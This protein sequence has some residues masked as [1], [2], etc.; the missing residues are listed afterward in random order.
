VNAQEP[1]Q[2]NHKAGY[3]NIIGRPNVGKSTLMNRLAGERLSIITSKAQTTRHR[4]LGIL[5]SDN[6]Q[7]VY[8]DT[9]GIIKPEYELHKSMMQFVRDSLEDAD[10]ILYV[11]ELNQHYREDEFKE[12]FG[13]SDAKI[14]FIL[15]KSDLGKK[16]DIDQ[17]LEY[18][19]KAW[20]FDAMFAVS[21][22]K[23]KNLDK[24]FDRIIDLLPVHPPYFPKDQLTDRP[25]RFFAAEILREKIF[26]NYAKEIPYSTEVA[27]TEFKEDEKII[28]IRAELFVERHSQK[29]ILIGKGGEALK[30]IGIQARKDLETFFGKQVFL[31]QYVRVE[32]DWRRRKNSLTKF[33]Y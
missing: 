31:E 32:K 12:L 22:L 25:E 21:A 5:N 24:V 33:G 26:M 20:P 1:H 13:K 4:I 11:A 28:R 6:F 17:N 10:V 8:S 30:K 3:V 29:G 7:V 23:G 16:E 14:I 2:D 27:V 19:K 9:P 18:W 15:N